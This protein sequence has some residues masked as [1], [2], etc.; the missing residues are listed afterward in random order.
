MAQEIQKI[1]KQK[2][3]P[4]EALFESEVAAT[5]S[6]INTFTLKRQDRFP[7]YLVNHS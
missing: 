3:L 1:L 2:G 6:A 5:D 4:L 7:I